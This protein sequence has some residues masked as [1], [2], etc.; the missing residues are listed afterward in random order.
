[1]ASAL[2]GGHVFPSASATAST[3]ATWE[4][5]REAYRKARDHAQTEDVDRALSLADGFLIE[6]PRDGR[7]LTYRGSLAAMRARV[8]WLPWKKL[9]MLQEGINQMDEGVS[10]VSKAGAG[11]EH[12]LEVR[13]VR[14]ISSAKIPSTFGRGGVAFSDFKAVVNHP[15]FAELAATHRATAKAWLAVMYR[16]QGQGA[17][18]ERLQSEAEALDAV[19]A[20]KVKEQAT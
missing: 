11:S 6:H 10:L 13:L 7:A 20:R 9:G 15:R 17:E 5:V 2:V 1:M 12:E 14:G 18:S 8:S 16:R 4:S 19:V 3:S